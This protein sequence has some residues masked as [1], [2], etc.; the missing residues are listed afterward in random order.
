MSQQ[1]I[2]ENLCRNCYIKIQKPSKKDIKKMVMS[3][4]KDRCD[5][6]GKVSEIVEYIED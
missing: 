5:K 2:Y 1:D 4:Y 3:E 6:C